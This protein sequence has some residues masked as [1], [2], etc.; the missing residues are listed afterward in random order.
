MWNLLAVEDSSR[1]ARAADLFHTLFGGDMAD[2]PY[3]WHQVMA[4][5]AAVYL[6]GLVIVRIGKSRLIGRNT[7]LDI[8]LGF[9]LGSLLSRGITGHASLSGTLIASSAL[10][11]IHWVI[12]ALTCRW[13]TLGSLFKGNVRPLVVDGQPIRENMRRS[14]ISEHD[15]LEEVR[16]SGVEE[17]EDVKRAYKE[18]NGQ[19][20]VIKRPKQPQVIN[21]DV[22]D[23]VQTLRIELV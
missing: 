4:R 13:H 22:R 7:A 15:L 19:V 18:R 23:G 5:A 10:I 11:A 6:I 14:H 17:I 9:I 3:T 2:P 20:S 8:I 12:T 1:L 21:I 16:L